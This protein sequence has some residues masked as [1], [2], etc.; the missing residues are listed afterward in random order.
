MATERPQLNVH[1]ILC[2]FLG[3][4]DQPIGVSFIN[5]LYQRR[6]VVTTLYIMYSLILPVQI[7]LINWVC[8][9]N[10]AIGLHMHRSGILGYKN[11]QTM[12]FRLWILID[13]RLKIR[14]A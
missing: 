4:Q 11:S 10:R 12:S 6:H 1:C 5:E 14:G 7:L 8:S 2:T 9:L 13:F 3:F